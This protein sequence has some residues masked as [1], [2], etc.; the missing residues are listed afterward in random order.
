MEN[1]NSIRLDKWLWTVRIYKTRSLATEACRL[2][3]VKINQIPAK[4]SREVKLNEIIV[5]SITPIEKTIKVLGV[6]KNRVSAKLA[7][8]YVEDL[9]PNEIYEKAELIRRTK[10]IF[11]PK[12]LGRPTKKERRDIENFNTDL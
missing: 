5:I 8:E 12:G 11:R 7:L 6:P 3:K 4:A 2:G 9:T 10:L 1:E